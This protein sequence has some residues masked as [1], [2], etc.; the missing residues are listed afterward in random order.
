MKKKQELLLTVKN[1]KDLGIIG[2][3]SEIGKKSKRRRKRIY[4]KTEQSNYRYP[5]QM[6]GFGTQ[7]NHSNDLLNDNLRLQNLKIKEEV[8]NNNLLTYND[9]LNKT[10]LELNQFKQNAL[11]FKTYVDKKLALLEDSVDV[12]ASGGSDFFDM[13][14][15]IDEKHKIDHHANENST[16]L[17]RYQYP[18]SKVVFQQSN[19]MHDIKEVIVD[20]VEDVKTKSTKLK[21]LSKMN[22]AELTETYK[23]LHDGDTTKIPET[24]FDIKLAINKFLGKKKMII[25]AP[26]KNTRKK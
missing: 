22:K 21:T 18:D 6:N 3:K 16:V 8:G 4:R 17:N 13:M 26:I 11:T 2:K 7:I 20:D 12:P 10:N 25:K 14:G 5:Y 9:N 23:R 24:V 1:L 15:N 19:P